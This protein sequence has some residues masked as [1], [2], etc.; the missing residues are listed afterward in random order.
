MPGMIVAVSTV[1]DTAGNVRRYVTRNLAN[2]IDHLVVFT[3]DTGAEAEAF[4]DAHPHV[5]HVPTGRGW[6]GE[7][8]SDDLNVRQRTAANLTRVLLAPFDWAEWIVHID[9]DEIALIDR[10]V[11]AAL[12][13][14]TRSFKLDPLEAVSREAWPSG[15]VTH[16]KRLLRDGELNVLRVLGLVAEP[17]NKAYFHGHVRGKRGVRVRDDVRMGL[18]VVKNGAGRFASAATDPGLRM[19]HLDSATAEEFSRKWMTLATSKSRAVYR[20]SRIPVVRALRTLSRLDVSDE[21]RERYLRRIYALTTLEDFDTLNDLGFLVEVGPEDGS[22][23]PQAAPAQ[24]LEVL[25]RLL[26]AAADHPRATLTLHDHEGGFDVLRDL[27]A[28]TG[29]PVGA[30]AG[31][32]EQVA[33]KPARELGPTRGQGGPGPGQGKN[34]G[35]QGQGKG[36]GQGKNKGG[37]NKGG[38]GGQGGGGGKGGKAGP[39]RT[40]VRARLRRRP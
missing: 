31:I 38:Q 6:W 32:L 34:N 22:H 29:V 11:V 2:G 18:H 12:P 28:T 33:R 7:H 8:R 25:A 23:Q 27:L 19:L 20:T 21:V 9:G 3:E 14:N 5:T 15:E 13:A 37:Q 40:G 35:G 10:D 4:L 1:K 24:D 26:A 39:R 17:T 36:K 30:A 16:F